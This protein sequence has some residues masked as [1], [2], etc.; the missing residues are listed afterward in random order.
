[1]TSKEW[2]EH[3]WATPTFKS[4]NNCRVLL[5][6]AMGLSASNRR[7]WTGNTDL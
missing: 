5:D 4:Y 7:T 2:E 3:Q 6:D 1:V